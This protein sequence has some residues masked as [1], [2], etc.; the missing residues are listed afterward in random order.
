[1]LHIFILAMVQSI[2][3]FLPI[4]SSAHLILVPYLFHWPDQGLLMDIGMH[5]GTLFAV[6]VYFM[7]DFWGMLTGFYKKGASQRLLLRLI[8]A[9][10]PILVAGFFLKEFVETTFRSPLIIAFTLI[11]FGLVL[12]WADKKGKNQKSITGMSF[13]D[14]LWI[15][16]AQC[17]AL[18]PGTSRSGITMTAG[19]WR[20]I[21]R[22]DATKFSMMLSVPTISAAAMYHL[23]R[24]FFTPEITSLDM[25]F[26]LGVFFSFAGGLVAV[27][28]LMKWVK[29]QSF[30]AFMVYRVVLGLYLFWILLH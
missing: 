9:T 10:L 3:E 16:L 12:Y 19:R 30:F 20:G 29:T 6:L 18:V 13:I 17:L 23:G 11:F 1:M 2:T 14:A 15:G 7:K 26:F 24:L 5:L 28:G 27:W 21:K 4:S 22:P 8:V 25:S